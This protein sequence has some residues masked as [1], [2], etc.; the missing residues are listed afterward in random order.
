MSK[1]IVL[2]DTREKNG[3]DFSSQ[4]KCMAVKDWGLRTGDYTARGLE[5]SLVIERK[6]STGE[7]AMNLGQKKNA[8]EA[9]MERMSKFRWAYIVCEFSIDDIM[10]FPENSGIPKKRW[11]YMRMNG[12]YI[13]KRI[14]EIEEEFGVVFLFLD[15]KHDAEDKVVRIFDE[16]TEI[17]IREQH[18]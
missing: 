11:Q 13:W 6:A 8:F 10:S 9:E 12:K 18:S 16:V 14:R 1:Y 7:I 17:L 4:D 2:R 15:N 3:W 5:K